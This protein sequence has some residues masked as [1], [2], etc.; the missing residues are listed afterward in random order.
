[1]S[2][3]PT[4]RR[5]RRA[6]DRLAAPVG[7]SKITVAAICFRRR[8]EDLQ[9]RLV[10]T[11]DGRRWTFP[12]GHPNLDE[13]PLQTAAREAAEQAGVT[14]VVDETPL[15][16]YGYGR[17]T[18]DIATAFLLA[19]QSTAPYGGSGRQATWFD[20]AA[21]RERLAEERHGE[22]AGELQ[23]VIEIAAHRLQDKPEA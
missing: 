8:D 5:S 15:T 14:G 3:D 18:D 23:G 17:R 10:R 22:L 1:M 21:T 12:K 16:E 6:R 20:L 13:T 2:S 19:V 11:T 4:S 7:G 9:F